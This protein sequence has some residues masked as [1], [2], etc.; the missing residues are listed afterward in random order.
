MKTI[1]VTIWA[2]ASTLMLFMC[3]AQ[4]YEIDGNPDRYL[5]VGL[6]ISAGKL[7][8]MLKDAPASYP[9]TDGG[10]VKGMLDIRM[11]VCGS[12]TVHAFG[13]STG[14]NNNLQFSEGNEIGLGLRV[15]V[16]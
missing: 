14:I 7:P 4:A 6:D 9:H 15:Y 5:S 13:S 3:N 11:P 12:L 1:I 16:R 8:G 2:V 10:F